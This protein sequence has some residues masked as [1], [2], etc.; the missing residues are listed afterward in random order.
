[1]SNEKRFD[2]VVKCE[3][4]IKILERDLSYSEAEK[5]LTEWSVIYNADVFYEPVPTLL[6]KPHAGN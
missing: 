3:S 1:V 5:K 6:I 4:E 2:L